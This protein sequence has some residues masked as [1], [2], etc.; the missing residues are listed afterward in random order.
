MQDKVRNLTP[1]FRTHVIIDVLEI[2][3][4]S[5]W[6]AVSWDREIMDFVV[7]VLRRYLT[8]RVIPSL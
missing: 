7:E 8:L 4:G 2:V 6:V 3:Q 1:A 5:D